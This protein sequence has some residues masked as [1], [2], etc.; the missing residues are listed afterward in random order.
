[1][2]IRIMFV[3]SP[4]PA[5]QR[6]LKQLTDEYG[7]SDLTEADCVVPIGGDGIALHALH[8]VLKGSTKPVFA[9][10]HEDSVGFLANAFSGRG[11]PQA[12][13]GSNEHSA[14]PP[15][16]RKY[17]CR[18]AGQDSVRDQRDYPGAADQAVSE[19]AP[20]C[21]WNRASAPCHWRR[22]FGR[23]PSGQHRLQPLGG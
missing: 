7:Q 2:T 16:S 15:A 8:T 22:D 12:H 17:G 23:H 6:A 18:W 11:P 4:K 19:T 20:D 5:A 10:R 13:S 3:A 9:M 14:L 1:M 21:E